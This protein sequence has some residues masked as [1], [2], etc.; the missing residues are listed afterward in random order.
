MLWGTSAHLDPGK[1]F[2]CQA[3]PEMGF[4]AAGRRKEKES[5]ALSTEDPTFFFRAVRTKVDK[6]TI[7][8]VD[9]NFD[10]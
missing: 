5:A 8:K 6:L 3:L 10:R 7:S 1:L 9:D 4:G 2:L